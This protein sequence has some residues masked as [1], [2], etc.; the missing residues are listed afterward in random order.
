[1][2]L[3]RQAK[4]GIAVLGGVIDPDYQGETGLLL[5]SGGKKDYVQTAEDPIGHLLVLL[6]PVTKVHGKL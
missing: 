3:S 2:P 1:M 5:H 6:C 4:T